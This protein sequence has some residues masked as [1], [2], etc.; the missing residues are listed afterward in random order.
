MLI[1]LVV[2]RYLEYRNADYFDSA[3]IF[4]YRNADYSGSAQIFSAT[5]SSLLVITLYTAT[6]YTK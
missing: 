5:M 4:E 3:Q 6:D 2:H 1:I